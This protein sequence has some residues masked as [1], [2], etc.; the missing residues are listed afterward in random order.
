MTRIK[1]SNW[2]TR[3]AMLFLVCIV[4]PPAFAQNPVTAIDVLL[5]PDAT[6][7]QHA[8]ANNDS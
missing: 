5:K 8:E 7:L 2:T 1:S 6:M 3:L 4:A